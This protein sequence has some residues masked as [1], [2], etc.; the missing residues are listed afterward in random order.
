MDKVHDPLIIHYVTSQKPWYYISSSRLRNK[1]WQYYLLGWS[2]IVNRFKFKMPLNFRKSAFTFT[3]TQDIVGIDKLVKALPDW[4]FN[5]A[6]YSL[7][8]WNLKQYIV[9]PNVR[10]WESVIDYHLKKLISESDVYLDINRG[11][12]EE[13]FITEFLNTGKPVYSLVEVAGKNF[14]KFCKLFKLSSF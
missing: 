9:N 7:F 2:D 12:K 10:C 13:K 1:W 5:F 8:G 11:P 3:N 14:A 6:A 4:K